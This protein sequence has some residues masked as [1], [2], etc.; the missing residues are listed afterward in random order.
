MRE[1]EAHGR[2]VRLVAVLLEEHPLEHASPFKPVARGEGRAVGEEEEDRVRLREKDPGLALQHG[3]PAFRVLREEF[4]G[5]RLA[6]QDV[7]LDPLERDPEVGEEEAHL[8][9]V[10]GREVVVEAHRGSA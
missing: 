5:P 7:H 1:P 2:D 3:D 9:A 8:V 4:R 6:L 10:A